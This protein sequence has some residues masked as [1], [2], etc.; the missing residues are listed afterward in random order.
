MVNHL[1]LLLLFVMS[2]SC[3]DKMAANGQNNPMKNIKTITFYQIKGMVTMKEPVESVFYSMDSV[4]TCK[5]KELAL[6]DGTRISTDTVKRIKNDDYTDKSMNALIPY[7]YRDSL[8]RQTYGSPNA[9]DSGG[10]GMSIQLKN[11]EEVIMEFD[12]EE[13]NVPGDMKEAYKV[14]RW[15]EMHLKE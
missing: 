3:N 10:W 6:Q 2:N 14:F 11:G 4:Q 7:P 5:I 15:L 1:L 8:K 13:K 9:D 12:N